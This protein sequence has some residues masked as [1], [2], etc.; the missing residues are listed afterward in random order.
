MKKYRFLAIALAGL[1]LAGCGSKENKPEATPYINT[2]PENS[3]ESGQ[4][5]EEIS[6]SEGQNYQSYEEFLEER[7]E[8]YGNFFFSKGEIELLKELPQDELYTFV[9]GDVSVNEEDEK[10]SEALHRIDEIEM[11]VREAEDTDS[12]GMQALIKEQKE[13]IE[14]HEQF[15]AKRLIDKCTGVYELFSSLGYETQLRRMT[16]VDINGPYESYQTTVKM[17]PCDIWELAEELNGLYTVGQFTV[18]DELKY[19]EIVMENKP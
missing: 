17:P 1:M 9:I 19:D 15:S 11:L 16:A 18:R 6:E 14:K 13:L 4:N 7:C 8:R 2:Q 3:A 5:R 10:D 12:E